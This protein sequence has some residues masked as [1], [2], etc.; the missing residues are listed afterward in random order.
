MFNYVSPE[1]CGIASS[2]I[3][4]FINTLESNRLST[5]SVIIARG[6]SIVF[7]K[8]WKPFHRDY[9]H[10]QY[11]VSKSITALA[12]GFL[13]QEGLINLDDPIEKYF[14]DKISEKTHPYLRKQ[15]I[16]NML[17]M[18]TAL[19][20]PDWFRYHSPD[21]LRVY[22]EHDALPAIKPGT[23]FRY[24]STG[25]FVIGA[26]VERISGMKLM[27]YLR[28]K[29]FDK[30]GVSK[31][32]YCLECP[33][34]HSWSDSAV[35]CTSLDLLK[36]A[37][38]TLNYGE[39][40]GEQ[41]I[42]RQ[43]MIDATSALVRNDIAN[44]DRFSTQGYG[45]YIWRT[46]ENS[47]SFNGMG[48]QYAICVPD[49]DIILIIQSDNQGKEE[50]AKALIFDSFFR[51]IVDPAQEG[52]IEAVPGDVGALEEATADLRL[53]VAVGKTSSPAAS[54]TEGKT[55]Y[56]EDNP[57]GW[58]KMKMHFEGDEGCVYYENAQG[59]KKLRFG[60]G[61]NVFSEFEQ[62]GYADKIGNIPGNRRYKCAASAVWMSEYSL[63]V[64][65]QIID[66]YFGTMDVV[67]AFD[68]DTVSVEMRKTAEDFLNEYQG[69]AFGVIK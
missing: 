50:Y 43:Y 40:N 34:G 47:F 18:T 1:K 32:A 44:E 12:V 11:S 59:E 23:I 13:V 14:P 19:Y 69:R 17:T 31:E 24:D 29:L 62:D 28:I 55:Y 2:S 45:Y 15:T 52:E 9:L 37:R 10:R 61:K 6:N 58:K 49:K 22:F 26:L 65:V 66:I 30:I 4:K 16:R 33:G 56:F 46:F 53:A 35:I 8:Y 57:M 64:K 25:T 42:D 3:L 41:I 38:F 67:F 27:D 36:I 20:G 63:T 60:F 21:R 7:E 51:Y 54:Q 5:H 48:C 68:G 39:W